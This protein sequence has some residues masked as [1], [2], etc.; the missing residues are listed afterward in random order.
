MEIDNENETQKEITVQEVEKVAKKEFALPLQ[1]A[2][3]LRNA[4]SLD[5]SEEQQKEAIVEYMGSYHPIFATSYTSTSCKVIAVMDGKI[6]DV[7][8]DGVLGGKIIQKNN[9]YTVIYYSLKNMTSEK[10][11]KQGDVIGECST[12]P[13][14]GLNEPH[15]SIGVMVKNAYVDFPKLLENN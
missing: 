1:D 10:Y 12:S 7:Q 6:E 13:F 2:I 15:V 8:E 9:D 14:D 4:Y 3:V 5:A 11:V